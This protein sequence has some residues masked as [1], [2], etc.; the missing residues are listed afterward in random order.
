MTNQGTLMY[1]AAR[2]TV[3]LKQIILS[4]LL[5]LALAGCAQ[6]QKQA[7]VMKPTAKL[8]GARLAGINFDQAKLVFDLA[9]D[10]PNP[11]AL[12]LAG[13]DY[14]FKIENQSLV[15][16]TS[17]KAMALKAGGTSSISLPVT[18][19]FADLKKLPGEIWGKDR[20]AYQLDTTFNINL[21]VIGNYAIPVS[22]SGEIPVPRMPKVKLKD[23]KL[24]NLGFSGADIIARV[25]V[26]NPNAFQLGMSDFSYQLNINQQ[27]W[28]AGAIKQKK[29]IAAKSRGIIE[30]PLSLDL[31]S[32]GSSAAK[33]LAGD[34]PLDYRLKGSMKV[35]TGIDL[36]KD[37]AVPLDIKG[38]V[39]LLR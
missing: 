5:L 11:V 4:A 32:M 13:L 24:K 6:L 3:N 29:T 31:L 35:D 20:L 15:S 1:K 7:E 2:Y 25:E 22:K 26:D 18:L 39:P 10:N 17:A 14:N 12:E 16:G 23:V 36:M 27:K 34:K 37:V 8:T 38:Q 28:G 33:L 9:V 21:P 19:K 30:V